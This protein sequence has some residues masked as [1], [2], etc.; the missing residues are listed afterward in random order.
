MPG[1][2]PAPWPGRV[3]GGSVDS[4]HRKG[5]LQ[6][7][8]RFRLHESRFFPAPLLNVGS[9]RYRVASAGAG[10]AQVQRYVLL[11]PQRLAATEVPMPPRTMYS[12]ARRV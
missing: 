11:L 6:R 5:A 7:G 4:R 9:P 2:A 1:A 3:A 10:K 12:I 8:L